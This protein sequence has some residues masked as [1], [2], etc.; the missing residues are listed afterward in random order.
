MLVENTWTLFYILSVIVFKADSSDLNTILVIEMN[1]NPT[2]DGYMNLEQAPKGS[3][4]WL[5][6]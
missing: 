6:P 3:G 5:Y 1:T 4:F 2:I